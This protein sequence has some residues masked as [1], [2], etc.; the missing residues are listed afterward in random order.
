MVMSC[1][2]L[3]SLSRV[4][5]SVVGSRW[6]HSILARGKDIWHVTDIFGVRGARSLLWLTFKHQHYSIF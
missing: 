1:I 5:A 3:L 6:R 4:V 2:E